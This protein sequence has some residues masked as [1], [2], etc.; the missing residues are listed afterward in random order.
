MNEH[1]ST[2]TDDS[3]RDDA[4]SMTER[5][6]GYHDV[7]PH[8][9]TTL[10]RLAREWRQ[11]GKGKCG[12]AL[13][14]NRARWELSLQLATDEAFVVQGTALFDQSGLADVVKSR[15]VTARPSS[16]SR[17]GPPTRANSCPA[18]SKAAARAATGRDSAMARMVAIDSARE[19]ITPG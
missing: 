12:I 10:L 5:F 11:S 9:Y 13:L 17:T 2:Q 7:N 6:L 15:S 4:P 8:V 16:A 3:G 14:Y 18:A 1:Q 19:R